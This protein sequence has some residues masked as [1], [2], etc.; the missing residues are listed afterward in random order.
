MWQ[1]ALLVL[2]WMIW[3]EKNSRIFEDTKRSVCKGYILL[4]ILFPTLMTKE[5]LSP[6]STIKS[7]NY[8]VAYTGQNRKDYVSCWW[9]NSLT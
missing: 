3:L 9:L 4:S 5:F 2:I 1:C 8:K 7:L 6:P